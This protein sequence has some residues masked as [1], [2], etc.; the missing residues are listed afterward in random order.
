MPFWRPFPFF[1]FGCIGLLIPLFLLFLAF[2]A[3]RRLMWGPR[4][5]WHHMRYGRWMGD[6]GEA[7]LPPMFAEWHRRAHGDAPTDK[8]E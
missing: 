7:G 4:W 8:K 6:E 1:G 3:F 2:G 5:G